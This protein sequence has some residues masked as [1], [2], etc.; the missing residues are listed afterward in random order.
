MLYLTIVSFIWAFSFVIIKGSLTG[1]DSNFVSFARLALSLLLF[2]PL[3]RLNGI[4]VRDRLL[5]VGIGGIQFGL[6]YV[7]YIATYQ[8]LPAHVIV[9]LTTTTPIF[10]SAVND[11]FSR[12]FHAVFLFSAVL[13]VLG[14]AVIRYPAQPLEVNLRGIALLQ[15]SNIAFAFGQVA[16]VW[17]MKT[18]GTASNVRVFGLLYAGAVLVAGTFSLVSTDYDAIQFSGSQ[19]L[20]LAYLGLIASGLCFFL[21]NKGATKVNA[22][23]LAIMNN[24][25]IPLGI[26][27]SLIF[28]R[29]STDYLRLLAGCALMAAAVM[30]NARMRKA[31]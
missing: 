16:Y 8:Y 18:V 26:I 31:G 4:R 21:W 3:M 22:G 7:A 9:L 14:G 28:L 25:K 5:L 10:V 11:I 2:L 29:E 23:M 17:V 13:A 6:M 30:V 27:A 19:V 24:L 12:R 20:A 15:F 1:L